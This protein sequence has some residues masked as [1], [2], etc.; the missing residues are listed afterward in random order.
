MNNI[1]QI[2]TQIKP[3]INFINIFTL[4]KDLG[5]K[6]S[7]EPKVFNVRKEWRP[8]DKQ[9]D[10]QISNVD[11][12]KHESNEYPI[13]DGKPFIWTKS[14]SDMVRRIYNSKTALERKRIF[15][16]IRDGMEDE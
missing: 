13:I 14:D 2:S 12:D 3:Q 9:I 8:N 1:T 6:H 4:K 7:K 5:M 10:Q 11:K 15:D 16:Y